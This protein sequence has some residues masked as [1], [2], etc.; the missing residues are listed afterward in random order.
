M[1][2]IR[3]IK[4][5]FWDSPSTAKAGPW[6]RL[7]FIAMWNW[8][9][10]YGR[11]TANLKELEGF[12]FPNDDTFTDCSGNTVQFRDVVAEVSEAFGVVFY[13]CDGRQFYAIPSWERHQRNERRAKD[14]KYP[15]P[16][17]DPPP[18]RGNAGRAEMHGI[19]APPERKMTDAPNI[20]GTGTGEQGNRGTGEQSRPNAVDQPE[21]SEWWGHYPKKVAKGQARTAYKTAAKKIGHSRLLTAV[22]AYQQ[23]TA[24]QD[25]KYIPNAATWLNG[26]RWDDR[27][28]P[29]PSP[30]EPSGG[31]RRKVDLDQA[32]LARQLEIARQLDARDREQGIA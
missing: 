13:E 9:D 25:L 4:P 21:F 32:A 1:A 14:S 29:T 6:A 20:S 2:R 5:E 8:A 22:I 19:S 24:G 30:G 15:E 26:E 23:Q 27:Q 18:T 10:D 17:D 31:Y 28:L 12:I 16:P 11:G 7:A 3:T